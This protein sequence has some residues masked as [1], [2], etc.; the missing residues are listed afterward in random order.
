M[1]IETASLTDIINDELGY[2][3]IVYPHPVPYSSS[4]MEESAATNPPAVDGAGFGRMFA[5]V[6][7]V[8]GSK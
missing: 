5:W 7:Y 1:N 3:S 6:L 4:A 8:G 2:P